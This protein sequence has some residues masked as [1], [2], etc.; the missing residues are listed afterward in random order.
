MTKEHPHAAYAKLVRRVIKACPKDM[1]AVAILCDEYKC[2]VLGSCC[3]ACSDAVIHH[4][5]DERP[6]PRRDEELEQDTPRVH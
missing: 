4:A 3:S 5:A 1:R 2:A 6:D